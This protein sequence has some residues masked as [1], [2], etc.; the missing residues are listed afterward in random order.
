MWRSLSIYGT[1]SLNLG[2]MV[3]GGYFLGRLI[4]NKYHLSNM[5]ATGVLTGLA[6]GFYEMFVIAYK[7][8]SKK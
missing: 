2:L 8:G 7:A 1:L 4:E 6:L 3:A 5:T